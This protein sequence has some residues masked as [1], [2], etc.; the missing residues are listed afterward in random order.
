MAFVAAIT[1]SQ[2]IAD[3]ATKRSVHGRTKGEKILRALQNAKST[4]K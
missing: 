2:W 4:Y 3:V 1:N